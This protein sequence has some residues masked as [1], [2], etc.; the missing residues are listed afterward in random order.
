MRRRSS[1]PLLLESGIDCTRE[2]IDSAG[3]KHDGVSA[4]LDLHHRSSDVM[5]GDG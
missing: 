5:V 1:T 3:M 4:S 2:V